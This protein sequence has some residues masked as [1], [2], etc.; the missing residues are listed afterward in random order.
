MANNDFNLGIHIYAV[1]G[2]V[3]FY[4][5]KLLPNVAG[6]L[7]TSAYKYILTQLLEFFTVS[8]KSD[9]VTRE[10]LSGTKQTSCGDIVFPNNV[11]IPT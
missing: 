5:D 3:T 9:C 6:L 8:T 11:I 4:N 7:F 1:D 2:C 10:N